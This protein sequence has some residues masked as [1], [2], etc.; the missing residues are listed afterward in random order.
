VKH[1]ILMVPII[2]LILL[3]SDYYYNVYNIIAAIRNTMDVYTENKRS[4]T[5]IHSDSFGD[6]LF[7][8]I[9]ATMVG[10]IVFT[11]RQGQRV[12]K[13]DEHGYFAFGGS[14]VI[15]F[16]LPNCVDFD[17]DLV[18]NSLKPIETLVKMGESVGRVLNI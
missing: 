17:Q 6:V 10:S 12:R 4:V 14:T 9:G 8:S 15:L 16:F 1:V 2:L 18:A 7:V 11:T 5:I 13:G 3:V